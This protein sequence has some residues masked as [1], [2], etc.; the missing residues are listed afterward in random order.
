MAKFDAKLV[1]TVSSPSGER[2]ILQDVDAAL[3]S[4]EVFQRWALENHIPVDPVAGMMVY[5]AFFTE[6]PAKGKSRSVTQNGWTV[7][8]DAV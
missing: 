7:T 8:F 2:Y 5:I 4:M 1:L 6:R 3:A